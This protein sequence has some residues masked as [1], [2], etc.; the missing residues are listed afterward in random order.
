MRGTKIS[1]LTT[2]LF[3]KQS[4]AMKL[5]VTYKGADNS[6]V[7][8]DQDL[9]KNEKEEKIG[10]RNERRKRKEDKRTQ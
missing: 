2:A 8:Q 6:A 10:K 5:Y 3:K 9:F 4:N 1:Q 7:K